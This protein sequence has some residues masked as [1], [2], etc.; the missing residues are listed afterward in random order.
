MQIAATPLADDPIPTTF[1]VNHP[2]SG[3]CVW[4]DILPSPN[5][6][7]FRDPQMDG[8]DSPQWTLYRLFVLNMALQ[9]FDGVATYQGLRIGFQEAN[10]I[11][12]HGFG[13]AGVLPTLLFYKAYACALLVMLHRIT[14]ARLGIPVMKG[15]AA[16][17]CIF[18]LGP[19]LGKFAS[20]VAHF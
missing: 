8:E 12:L 6:A 11:L 1:V 4:N 2:E 19:W 10:P 15:L 9:L 18:S 13:T 20:V 16:V 17:Y 14:P 7:R 3:T 5:V